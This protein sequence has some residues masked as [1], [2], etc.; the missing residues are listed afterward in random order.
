MR[1]KADA[2][3]VVVNDMAEHRAVIARV[4]KA[5]DHYATLSVPRSADADAVKRAYRALSLQ[6]HPDR[7]GE[8]GAEEAFKQ[9]L[10]AYVVLSDATQRTLYDGKQA[11]RQQPEGKRKKKKA[12]SPAPTAEELAAQ[13][14]LDAMLQQA[15]ERE[16]HAA[17]VQNARFQQNSLLLT[18][19]GAVAFVLL[20][21][22][23][24]IIYFLWPAA[25]AVQAQASSWSGRLWARAA[26]I[27]VLGGRF[28]A[29]VA[30]LVLL[31]AASPFAFRLFIY[32]MGK[33]C[34]C[35]FDGFELFGRVVGPRIEAYVSGL[36]AR[37]ANQGDRPRRRR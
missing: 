13:R 37:R 19:G 7:N 28:V 31:V 22:L 24:Y 4:A 18:A 35:L 14:E 25:D 20:G 8:P 36:P 21:I 6:L 10:E 17:W 32:G 12:A 2:V 15:Y 9:L 11:E 30:V 3:G 27:G 5:A 26:W 16:R 29:A 23:A 1:C 34:E 33:L